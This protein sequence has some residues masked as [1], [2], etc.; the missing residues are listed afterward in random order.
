MS[1]ILTEEQQLILNNVKEFVQNE[2]KP[3]VV[4]IDKTGEFPHDLWK[5]CAEMGLTGLAVSE[6]YGGL[7]QGVVMEQLVMEEIAKES[8]VLALILDAHQLSY[9]VIQHVGTEEQKKKYLPPLASGEKI[10]ALSATEACGST[11]FPEYAPMKRDGDDLILNCTKIFTTN[12]HVAD[13]YT[14]LGLLDGGLQVVIVEKGTPGLETGHI[15]HKLGMAGSYS[16]NVRFNNVRVP[17]ENICIPKPGF[18]YGFAV[19]YLNISAI[20]L[21]LSEGVLEKTKNYVLNR[22]R[23]GKPL[24]SFQVVAHHIAKMQTQIELAR[25]ILYRAAELYDEGTP[26]MMLVSMT[27]VFATEMGVDIANLCIQ[28]HGAIGYGEDT[29]IAR[30]FRDAKCNTIGETSTDIHYDF[31]AMYLGMPID[32]S[33]PMFIL[34]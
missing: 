15:E 24:A 13:Y 7:D 29:G 2:V 22:S 23:L 34:D 1:I 4:D 20:S 32:T 21:G 12:A 5:R 31:I 18:D 33:I 19:C 26:N 9:R 11:N 6:E 14:V 3:R 30:Y 27:K 10:T 25:S 8:P 28:L 17:K 16:G